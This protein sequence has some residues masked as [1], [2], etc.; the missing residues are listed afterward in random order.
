MT[1]QPP[2][3]SKGRDP[4]RRARPLSLLPV[5]ELTS[6]KATKQPSPRAFAGLALSRG[7]SRRRRPGGDR[8]WGSRLRRLRTRAWP[9][10][11]RGQFRRHPCLRATPS[12]SGVAPPQA[13]EYER[14]GISAWLDL[15]ASPTVPARVSD[16]VACHGPAPSPDSRVRLVDDRVPRQ[17]VGR[18]AVV[19]CLPSRDTLYAHG[20]DG[21]NVP[22]NVPPRLAPKDPRPTAVLDS[23]SVYRDF[24]IETS[25]ARGLTLPNGPGHLRTSRDV[26]RDVFGRPGTSWDECLQIGIF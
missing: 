26:F 13:S 9:A 5:A 1:E 16:T 12:R 17:P 18:L 19:C 3:P 20:A 15:T 23:S 22:Q 2:R 24:G 4:R 7:L 11:V 8:E 14:R 25:A 6:A 21:Q 10:V